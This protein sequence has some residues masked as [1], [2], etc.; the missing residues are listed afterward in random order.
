VLSDRFERRQQREDLLFGIV[1]A[2]TANYGFYGPRDSWLGPWDFVHSLKRPT[3][4]QSEEEIAAHFDA[5]LAPVAVPAA[6]Q[7]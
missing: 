7:T 5:M 2:A 6:S 1:A 4:E 3:A